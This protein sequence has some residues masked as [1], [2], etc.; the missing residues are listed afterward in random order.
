MCEKVLNCGRL[1]AAGLLF[2]HGAGAT[3]VPQLSFEELTDTSELVVSGTVT[4]SW[5]AWD[6]NH[7]YIWTH[8][9]LAVAAAAK[10]APGA[11]VEFAEP[12]GKLDGV[13]H[14]IAGAVTFQQGESVVLFLQRMPNGY[15][16]TTGWGQGK[17]NLDAD[18]RMRGAS[19]LRGVELVD[20]RKGLP[21]GSTALEA[22][23]G[24]TLSEL[25]L[26]ISARMRLAGQGTGR[27]K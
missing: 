22:L 16:R 25:S 23:N 9:E 21:P 5:A 10:G 12:G 14:A 20:L 3:I 1:I 17:Y 15:L 13:L 2:L 6:A 26:R 7:K 8:Y 24:M 27:A 11:K 19:A 18:R 4:R